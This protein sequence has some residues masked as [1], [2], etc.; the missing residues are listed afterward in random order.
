MANIIDDTY[1]EHGSLFIPNNKDLTVEPVDSPTSITE[2]EF[3]IK[4][5]ERQFLLDA[6]GVT[7]YDELQ[8]ALELVDFTTA[9]QKWQDLVNGTNYTDPNGNVRRWDG[10]KGYDKQSVIAFYIFTEYLRNDNETYTTTGVVKND[11]KNAQVIDPTPK[12]IKA[13][14]QFIEAYQ[15]SM[16]VNT[17]VVLINGFGTV[18]LDYYN[19]KSVQVSLLRFLSDSNELDETAYPDFEFRLYEPQN[20]FGI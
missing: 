1:F 13:Y 6:L 2:L 18:G 12:Y 20:S 3:F 17:P 9:E 5:Y 15:G 8:V 7:L 14:N 4:K 16:S 10:L 11:A 19:N